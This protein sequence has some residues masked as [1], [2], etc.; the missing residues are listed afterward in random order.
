M[1]TPVKI[2]QSVPRKNYWINGGFHIWQRNTSVAL[3]GASTASYVADRARTTLDGTTAAKNITC[4]QNADVP[5]FLQSRSSLPWSYNVNFNAALASPAATDSILTLVYL[6]EGVDFIDLY[7]AGKCT[8]EFWV[9]SNV[10]GPFSWDAAVFS[11]NLG[12]RNIGA[13]YE[14]TAGEVNTWVRRTITISFE[15]GLVIPADNQ[16]RFGISLCNTL[17]GSSRIYSAPNTWSPTDNSGIAGTTNLHA[18]SGNFIRFAGAMIYPGD[19][20]PDYSFILSGGGA[21]Q[22]EV[23]Q[24]MRYYQ[25]NF[26]LNAEGVA[27][28]AGE[29]VLTFKTHV[30]MRANPALALAPG[31]TYASALDETGISPRT[32]TSFVTSG[33]TNT[34]FGIIFSGMTGLTVN[35]SMRLTSDLLQADAEL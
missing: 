24:C 8:I 33:V 11:T 31:S 4:S 17:I 10:A 20:R 6:M 5:S 18:A 1:G 9:K 12:Q 3:S 35:R 29:A 15:S 23:L 32:P 19:P 14:Y 2:I 13:S 7:A 27:I 30:P 16:L 25:R 34:G 28:N 26:A 22:S 21:I